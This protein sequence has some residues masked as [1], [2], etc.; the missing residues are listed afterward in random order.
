MNLYDRVQDPT[1]PLFGYRFGHDIDF[2][3]TYGADRWLG[4]SYWGGDTPLPTAPAQVSTRPPL[5]T[6]IALAKHLARTREPAGA[7]TTIKYV[8]LTIRVKNKSGEIMVL[9]DPL[10][11]KRHH[12]WGS[13]YMQGANSRELYMYT[14]LR[15][16]FFI[17]DGKISE[18]DQTISNLPGG[19]PNLEHPGAE[20]QP[21]SLNFVEIA[22]SGD[23]SIYMETAMNPYNGFA[24]NYATWER[25]FRLKGGVLNKLEP[26]GVFE[27]IR[28]LALGVPSFMH[29]Y[30]KDGERQP[31][32]L[33]LA[34]NNHDSYGTTT[35]KTQ[36]LRLTDTTMIAEPAIVADFSQILGR[37]IATSTDE[38]TAVSAYRQMYSLGV[39]EGYLLYE[40]HTIITVRSDLTEPPVIYTL[41]DRPRVRLNPSQDAYNNIAQYAVS[42]LP[43]GNN[44]AML[45]HKYALADSE[46]D[47]TYVQVMY[48]E[49]VATQA[50]SNAVTLQT[51]RIMGVAVL[52][53][54]R[55]IVWTEQIGFLAPIPI[56]S[57]IV[58][59]F[60]VLSVFTWPAYT[61]PGGAFQMWEDGVAT[62]LTMES[63]EGESPSENISRPNFFWQINRDGS[64]QNLGPPVGLHTP[65]QSYTVA[66][67]VML[68]GNKKIVVMMLT[69]DGVLNVSSD[70][71]IYIQTRESITPFHPANV[72]EYVT[73][74]PGVFGLDESSF[75]LAGLAYSNTHTHNGTRISDI[76]S[77][78]DFL[79]IVEDVVISQR[80][81]LTVSY[82][83]NNEQNTAQSHPDQFLIPGVFM[84]QGTCVVACNNALYR[85]RTKGATKINED[86][87]FLYYTKTLIA[88]PFTEF[89][90][91]VGF[92][93]VSRRAYLVNDQICIWPDGFL[94][95]DDDVF[96]QKGGPII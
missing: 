56:K 28:F 75:C 1:D 31:G 8:D 40:Q 79:T 84:H 61:Y 5:S 69:Y 35:A 81:G 96:I 82:G 47:H 64:I 37:S 15:Q 55:I 57:H 52:G 12:V 43:T 11:L 3:L 32:T 14:P 67:S 91:V 33:K 76:Y 94:F 19:P 92:G 16:I 86:P 22:R 89:V 21:S 65:P 42:V 10:D 59:K 80:V 78:V 9:R 25:V 41:P 93:T 58:D 23:G 30:K 68:P 53:A 44:S 36:C 72:G 63:R 45:V 51:D 24:Y 29:P 71:L 70:L 17:K 90:T 20:L 13:S 34:I 62:L 4:L 87:D 18:V 85:V 49:S 73:Y 50:F 95:D 26:V 83:V 48:T 2:R 7:T 60:D 77:W 88:G 66:G 54:S 39:D 38:G 74:L 27:S 46:I 6:G